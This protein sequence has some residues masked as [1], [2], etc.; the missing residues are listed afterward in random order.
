MVTGFENGDGFA[1]LLVFAAS[2]D[3]LRGGTLTIREE[4]WWAPAWPGDAGMV[5]LAVESE[6]L[7][8]AD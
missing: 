6:P 7:R 8:L 5:G 3:E 1:A 2:V 4:S